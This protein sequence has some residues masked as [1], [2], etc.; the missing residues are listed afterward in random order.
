MVLR[1]SV[2]ETLLTVKEKIMTTTNERP[3]YNNENI[4]AIIETITSDFNGY[5]SKYGNVG[6]ESVIVDNGMFAKKVI[7]DTERSRVASDYVSR[8]NTFLEMIK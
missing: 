5:C 4:S 6:D 8:V 1:D 7:D 2:C 3:I